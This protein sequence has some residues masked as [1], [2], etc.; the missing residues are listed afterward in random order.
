[1]VGLREP[2]YSAMKSFENGDFSLNEL[3]TEIKLICI[4]RDEEILVNDKQLRYLT[5]NQLARLLN[6]NALFR[7]ADKW[8]RN[9]LY[10]KASDFDAKV[11]LI[12]GNNISRVKTKK[13]IESSKDKLAKALLEVKENADYLEKRKLQLYGQSEGYQFAGN[14]LPSIK[15]VLEPK[16]ESVNSETEKINGVLLA[17]NDVIETLQK[18]KLA[19]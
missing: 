2:F 5:H 17:L 14:L 1:M 10:E 18:H 12:P 11:K 13:L 4:E 7:Y 15:D 6:K 16:L 8:A 19:P 3:I 9:A